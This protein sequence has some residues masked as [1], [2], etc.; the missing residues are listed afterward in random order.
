MQLHDYYIVK[1]NADRGRYGQEV[2]YTA[3]S[4]YDEK[5]EFHAPLGAYQIND[6]LTLT[7]EK[8]KDE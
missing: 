8:D 5:L 2:L 1:I 3:E 6:N 4:I 7:V